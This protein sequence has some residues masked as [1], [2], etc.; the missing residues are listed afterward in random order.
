MKTYPRVIFVVALVVTLTLLAVGVAAAPKMQP[1]APQDQHLLN[2]AADSTISE[3]DPNTNFGSD[4]T[5]RVAYTTTTTSS[6]RLLIRFDLSDIPPGS[7]IDSASL[8]LTVD[9]GESYGPKPEFIISKVAGNWAENG[10][11][12]NN[13]P[14]QGDIIGQQATTSGALIVAI[15]AAVQNW[16]NG[17]ANWGLEISGPEGA[18]A[19]Q[20]TYKSR[21]D[22]STPPRLN[23]VYTPPCLDT[24]EPNESFAHAIAITPD[25]DTFQSYICT[26][27]DVDFFKFDLSAN[28]SIDARLTDLPA[29]YELEIYGPDHSLLDRSNNVGTNDEHAQ[30]TSALAGTHYVK[31]VS[32][33]G[34][35]T[36]TVPYNLRVTAAGPGTPTSTPTPTVAPTPIT[37]YRYLPLLHKRT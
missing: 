5:L 13:Y 25:G 22:L 4:L 14:G 10:V 31:V 27:D 21:D 17:E 11:T 2:P 28:G 23:V 3:A 35:F 18:D 8:V 34:S 6:E 15:T 12:W 1:Q 37:L 26:T 20:W 24:F 16:V 33:L 9:K 29:N 7:T 19:F 32:Y 36:R 30:A